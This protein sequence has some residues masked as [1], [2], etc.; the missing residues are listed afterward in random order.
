MPQQNLTK[1][2]VGRRTA[3]PLRPR[4][5]ATAFSKVLTRSWSLPRPRNRV[6]LESDL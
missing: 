3:M 6:T 5:A 2:A 4:A 1:S